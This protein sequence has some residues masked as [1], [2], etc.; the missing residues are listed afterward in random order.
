[1]ADFWRT[2]HHYGKKTARLV[3]VGG[4]CPPPSTLVTIG[5]QKAKPTLI[6]LRVQLSNE[7]IRQ[8]AA[9]PAL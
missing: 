3:R 4:T 5:R 7:K 8:S 2:F 9:L 6:W 1:M